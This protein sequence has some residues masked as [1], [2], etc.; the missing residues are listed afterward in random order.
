MHC[1]SHLCSEAFHKELEYWGINEYLLDGCCDFKHFHEK[2]I[3][4]KEIQRE[5]EKEKEEI[6]RVLEENF[7]MDVIGQCREFLWDLT[8]HPESSNAARV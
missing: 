6:T 1:L 7:G 8:E 4:K 2:E 5:Q 3:N